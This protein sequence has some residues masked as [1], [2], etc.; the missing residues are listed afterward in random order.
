MPGEEPPGP[1]GP[2]PDRRPESEETRLLREEVQQ[3]RD[4]ARHRGEH[5]AAADALKNRVSVAAIILTTA[6]SFIGNV[7]NDRSDASSAA[8]SQAEA[9]R[10]QGAELWAYY[11]TKLAERTSLEL[12]RDRVRLDLARRGLDRR[13]PEARLDAFKLVNYEE[14]IRDFADETQR[15]FF[16]VQDLERIEDLSQRRA[17]EPARSAKRYD[18]GGKLITLALILLSVTILSNK[19]WLLFAGIGL[20]AVGLLV[21]LDGY[22]LFV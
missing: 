22:F 11:Q 19:Q 10:R 1:S 13:D 21:A 7:K 8:K 5:E 15:V 12:A 3:Q 4:E 16:R 2:M 20:G 17:V 18:L 14:H 9:A 6:L